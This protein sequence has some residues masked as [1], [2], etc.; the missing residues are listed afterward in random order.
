MGA[1]DELRRLLPLPAFRRLLGLRLLSQSAD[2]VVQAALASYLFFSPERQT[3]PGAIAAVTV[4][5]LLPFTLVGPFTGVVLD[6]WS[7]RDVLVGATLVRAALALALAAVLA[8]GGPDVVLFL[9]VVAGF[10]VNRF[11]LAGLSAALPHVVRRD[12]LLAANAVV[13]TA[14]T[15]A[16]VVGLGVGGVAQVVAGDPV[17]VIAAG[18]V[19]VLAAGLGHGFGRP[20]LGPEPDP[21]L[22]PAGQAVRLAL[23]GLSAAAAHLRE[24]PA[25]ERAI[26]LVAG[27]RLCAAL[28]L[29]AGILLYRSTYAAPDDPQAGLAGLS[30]SLLAAGVG[31]LLAA[32]ATP[33]L[34]DR[35]S[36]D[37]AVAAG[38]GV[39]AVVQAGF[40]ATL[41]E[42]VLVLAAFALGLG[43]QVVKICADTRVQ[44]EVDDQFRGRVFVLY[45]MAFNAALIAASVI[46]AVVL[47][48][49]GR[50]AGVMAAV[51]VALVL[52]AAVSARSGA[53][54]RTR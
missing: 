11:V 6:R 44:R 3:T 46:G 27:Q 23:Q 7:R 5:T 50:A 35:W 25:A 52:L 33:W 26:G 22:P 4:A 24:R 21:T 31:F 28:T 29:M 2:G 10:G 13:P 42:P 38:L 1:L 20:A 41:A 8:V 9:V 39:G 17:L 43:G 51:A 48:P 54:S 16:Y 12:Q 47:P 37:T 18:G 19:W 30:V 32:V 36:T 14:G 15:L 40:A 34:V 45:D 53:G 49:S